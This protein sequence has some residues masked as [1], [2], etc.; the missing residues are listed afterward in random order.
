MSSA[1]SLRNCVIF[2]AVLYSLRGGAQEMVAL[3]QD[4]FSGWV[5]QGMEKLSQ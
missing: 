1:T 4:L 5:Q 3:I 2:P